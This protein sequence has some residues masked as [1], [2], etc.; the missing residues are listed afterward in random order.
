[1]SRRNVVVFLCDQLRADY[2]RAYGCDAIETPAVDW[3]ASQGTTFTRA[4][5][6]ATICG[7]ARATMMTGRFVSD[8]GAWTNDLPWRDGLETVAERMRA[9]GYHTGCFG[10]MHHVPAG[11]PKGFEVAALFEENRQGENEGYLQWL[12]ETHPDA[13]GCFHWS[14]NRSHLPEEL[15]Y[16]HWIASRAIDFLETPDERPKL[17][18]VSFQGPHSPFDP[19]DGMT[20]L[21]DEGRLPA[22]VDP[23]AEPSGSI[24]E[25]RAAWRQI[26]RSAGD[27]A[28]VRRAYGEMIAQIDRQ[29]ARVIRSLEAA[30][31]LENTTFLFTADH[32]DELGDQ[33]LDKKGPFATPGSLQIPLILAGHP[34]VGQAMMTDALA[35]NIDIG[36]TLLEIA[37]DRGGFGHSR[38][39]IDL[40]QGEPEHARTV[41][42][43]E[44]TDL[45]KVAQNGR[46]RL[47]YY[48]FVQETE[49][50]D[51]QEDPQCRTNLAGRDEYASVELSLQRA[52]LDHAALCRGPRIN[53]YEMT[54]PVQA[55]MRALDPRFQETVP[56]AFPL[57]GRQHRRLRERGLDATYNAFC[58][59]RDVLADYG[60]YWSTPAVEPAPASGLEETPCP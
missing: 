15:H 1:M 33:G 48:S 56:V 46:Y 59:E 25:V 41:H 13:M 20:D 16:E 31:T 4:I 10:K 43:A 21:V 22:P 11:D 5:T 40:A 7:P 8:H 60:R 53:A 26:P 38:S 9:A 28:K 52:L 45:M 19:V 42:F 24:R 2:L 39:L 18:W 6:Q 51:L 29:I 44:Y 49:L 54:K 35:G 50:Y 30:G 58:R 37:G 57:N 34:D 3:L 36:A 47:A 12:R 14:K 23:D 32:G 55:G 17:A 27:L